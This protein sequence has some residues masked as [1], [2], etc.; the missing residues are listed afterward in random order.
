MSA[1]VSQQAFPAPHHALPTPVSSTSGPLIGNAHMDDT[2]VHANIT[3]APNPRDEPGSTQIQNPDL[4]EMDVD[5]PEHPRTDHDRQD[6]ESVVQGDAASQT[7]PGQAA[8]ADQSMADVEPSLVSAA[9]E[10]EISLEQLQK[11]MGE[12]FLL[13]RTRK[14]PLV[15]TS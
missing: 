7:D 3:Q 11:N 5:R 15:L 14:T 10:G 4:D 1:Q 12:A 9:S 2:D 8:T 6:A 13:C